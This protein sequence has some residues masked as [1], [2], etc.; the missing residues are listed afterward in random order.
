[1]EELTSILASVRVS[2]G[3]VDLESRSSRVRLAW[4]VVLVA[5]MD[6][7]VGRLRGVRRVCTGPNWISEGGRMECIQ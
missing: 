2:E 1:V 7:R 6:T 3:R 5:D 4:K